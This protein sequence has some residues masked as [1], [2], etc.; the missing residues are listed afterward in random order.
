MALFFN[1]RTSDRAD[2][3]EAG[4]PGPTDPKHHP[5]AQTVN[6]IALQA[7]GHLAPDLT[8]STARRVPLEAYVRQLLSAVTCAGR[9][10]IDDVLRDM[11]KAWICNAEIAEDYVPT[12]ARRLG[13][14]WC[15]DKLDFGA[16][17]IGCARLQGLLHRLE[18]DWGVLEDAHLHGRPGYLVGVPAGVQHTMGASVLAGQLRHRNAPARCQIDLTPQVLISALEETAFV[19]ILLSGSGKSS[20][21]PLRDLVVSARKA[22]RH[23]PVIIGGGIVDHV[24]DIGVLTGAD[25]VTNDLEDAM[26]YCEEAM[27]LRAAAGEFSGLEIGL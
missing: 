15:V 18:A 16:V 23:V 5:T 22:S 8:V 4:M 17:T 24:A 27:A 2:C 12:V 26:T 10:D 21:E 6:R 9:R 19:G 13:D 25:L 11:R 20:L 7:M 1:N 14:A 3:Q